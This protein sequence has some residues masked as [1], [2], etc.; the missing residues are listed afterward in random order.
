MAHHKRPQSST[1]DNQQLPPI[2]TRFQPG[3]SGNPGGRPKKDRD[4]VQLINAELDTTITLTRDGK[5]VKLTKRELMVTSL[6]NDAAKGNLKA[7]DAVV[8]YGVLTSVSENQ[9]VEVSPQV[10]AT[11]L[12]SFSAPRQGDE[13]SENP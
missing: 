1:R 2:A 13:T 12:E 8:R 11:F 3:Q 5:R 4:L 6:V 10:I 7:I 9:L